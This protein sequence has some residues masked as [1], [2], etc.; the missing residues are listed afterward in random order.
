MK[1]TFLSLTIIF[2]PFTVAIAE[3]PNVRISAPSFYQQNEEQIFFCPTDSNYVIANWREVVPAPN[4]LGGIGRSTDGGITWTSHV[5]SLTMSPNSANSDPTIAVDSDGNFYLSFLDFI[6]EYFLQDSSFVV[7]LKSVDKGAT[8]SG[9]YPVCPEPGV[10]FDDKQMITVDRTG[11]LYHGNVYVM[12]SRYFPPSPP[13]IPI[14][15]FAR[16]TDGCLTFEEPVVIGPPRPNPGCED[17]S[18][19]HFAQP[20]VGPDGTI[21]GFFST[22]AYDGCEQQI[23]YGELLMTKSTDGGVTWPDTPTVIFEY[24]T[25]SYVDG[26]VNVY[27]APSGSVDISGGSHSGNIYVST[28][29]GNQDEGCYHSDVIVIKSTDGGDSWFPPIR[30]NDDPLGEDVDQFHPWLVTNEDGVIAVIF[31]DQRTHSEHYRFDAFAA[32]S[33]DGA[34]TFTTNHRLS[35]VSINPDILYAAGER[36]G[37]IAEYIGI[38]AYHNYIN[39]AWTDTRNNNQ[40]VYGAYYSIPLLKPRLYGV[41]DGSYLGTVDDSLWWSACWPDGDVQYRILIATDSSF[42]NPIWNMTTGPN[43]VYLDPISLEDVLFYWRVRAFKPGI[44]DST[45]WSDTWSFLLDRWAPDGATPL[46]PAGGVVIIDSTP[47]FSWTADKDYLGSPELFE[48]EIAT[49]STFSGSPPFFSFSEIPD[50]L[51]TLPDPLPD[52]TVYYWHVNHYDSAG[53]ESGFSETA[54]FRL[55]DYCCGDA[56]ASGDVDIDDGTRSVRI[57]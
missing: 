43:K 51:F 10:Y 33:F 53:N 8:W 30:V 22:H 37:K 14:A 50:T 3:V 35:N 46:S 31:Y 39:A 17:Q 6:Q 52:D 45:E 28:T 29:N 1:Q 27:N 20:M 18:G 57:W 23:P 4:R 21:Y 11:G 38:T 36:A 44:G 40:D 24:D 7:F 13:Y 2:V 55:A 34:E 19:G 49:D 41:P 32:Y 5:N 16:S 9:P 48:I 56:D 15:M 54:R 42:N 47:T 25:V 12:W 26:N